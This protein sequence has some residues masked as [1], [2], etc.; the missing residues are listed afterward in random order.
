MAADTVRWSGWE[1][2]CRIRIGGRAGPDTPGS[3]C[4]GAALRGWITVPSRWFPSGLRARLLLIVFLAVCG[5]T[6]LMLANEREQ[7]RALRERVC[8]ETMLLSRLVAAH[9]DRLLARATPAPTPERTLALAVS[10]AR[11]AAVLV[12]LEPRTR[13]GERVEFLI[14]DREG[15]VVARP[16]ASAPGPDSQLAGFAPV[17][18]PGWAQ[19][20]RGGDGHRHVAAFTPVTAGGVTYWAGASM[21]MDLLF[22]HETQALLRSLGLV[23]LLGLLVAALAWYGASVAV[24]RRVD[25]LLVATSRL[26]AGDLSA[27]TGLAHVRGELGELGR[28]FDAMAE[29]IERHVDEQERAE[30]R[31]RLSEARKSAVLEASLDGILLLDGMGRV[32]ECN[33][34]ARRMFGCDGRRCVHHRL[35]ELFPEAPAIDAGA[36][37]SP[38]EAIATSGRRLDASTFPAEISIAPIRDPSAIGLFAATVRDV[39]ERRQLERTLRTL[40]YVDELTGLYNRRGF[41]M[42]AEHQLKLAARAGQHVV[43]VEVD[44]D[45]LKAINDTFGHANGDRALVELAR[46]LRASFRDTDIVGR[47]GGDEF[48]VLACESGSEGAET[49]IERFAMR[50]AGRNGVGDLPWTLSASI[51]WVRGTPEGADVLPRLLEMGDERMYEDKRRHR[52]QRAAARGPSLAPPIGAPAVAEVPVEGE[53]DATREARR[54]TGVPAERRAVA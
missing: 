4:R 33:A 46:L 25:A 8:A 32:M 10:A 30:R 27:R 40:S 13:T 35:A 19:E 18:R 39:T 45:G 28:Q 3:A 20:V 15:R 21:D 16:P 48:V 14:L 22:A 2:S 11:D 34:A 51:G 38:R 26:R 23:A 29:A 50:L 54:A 24:L 31:L 5:T 44:L 9:A 36:F 42:F 17:P 6:L 41:L 52:G 53:P 43:L 37:A 7:R 47:M 49:A 1:R 12:R